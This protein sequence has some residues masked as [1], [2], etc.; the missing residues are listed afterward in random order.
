ML[1]LDSVA[2]GTQ[3]FNDKRYHDWGGISQHTQLPS[4]TDHR[5]LRGGDI[6]RTLYKVIKMITAEINDLHEHPTQP[7]QERVVVEKPRT[8]KPI[9]LP[10]DQSSSA[11][12]KASRPYDRYRLQSA[13]GFSGGQATGETVAPRSAFNSR[14]NDRSLN[15]TMHARSATPTAFPR[16]LRKAQL[17]QKRAPNSTFRS[18]RRRPIRVKNRLQT[19][20]SPANMR[21]LGNMDKPTK[22]SLSAASIGA[23]QT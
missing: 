9:I 15:A 4:Q 3:E 1:R 8:K 19:L 2:T 17:T 13:Y 16:S 7:A 21:N 10:S 12:R 5:A 18:N 6:S 20:G 22:I 11:E 23:P 14:L